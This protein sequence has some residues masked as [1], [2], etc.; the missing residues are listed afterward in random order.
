MDTSEFADILMLVSKQIFSMGLFWGL[1][2]VHVDNKSPKGQRSIIWD[3]HAQKVKY[4]LFNNQG[5]QLHSK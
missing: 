5:K 1:T 2:P 3:Q 4:G